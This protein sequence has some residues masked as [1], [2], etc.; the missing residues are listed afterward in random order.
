[1]KLFKVE[2]LKFKVDLLIWLFDACREVSCDLCEKTLRSLRFKKKL[3]QLKLTSS[4][5][6]Q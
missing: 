6:I 3:T 2:C 4:I 5:I 1:M